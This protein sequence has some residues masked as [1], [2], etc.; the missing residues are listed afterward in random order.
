VLTINRRFIDWIIGKIGITL[1]FKLD[2]L[3]NLQ[4]TKTVL[5]DETLQ[6]KLKTVVFYFN[7]VFSMHDLRILTVN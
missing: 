4:N 3:V 6:I 2:V 1:T 7:I 5:K